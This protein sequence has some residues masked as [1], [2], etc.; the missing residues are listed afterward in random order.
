M[1]RTKVP[2]VYCTK[3]RN[4]I[5]SKTSKNTIA[6]FKITICNFYEIIKFITR[7][8]DFKQLIYLVILSV[9]KTCCVRKRRETEIRRIEA[10][11]NHERLMYL[12][13][14]TISW[15]PI[16]VF[17]IASATLTIWLYDRAGCTRRRT[18]FLRYFPMWFRCE[19]V[20][21]FS[22]SQTLFIIL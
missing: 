6:C 8:N 9:H 11:K 10:K 17:K 21:V 3:P 16:S 7:L 14:I 12:L 18:N 15:I 4:S 22:V 2:T 5:A 13:M 20:A 1:Y 19:T